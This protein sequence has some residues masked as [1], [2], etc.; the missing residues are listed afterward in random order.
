MSIPGTALM[1]RRLL[2]QLPA[3]QTQHTKFLFLHLISVFASVCN[4]APVPDS[5]L[6]SDSEGA[7]VSVSA[8]EGTTLTISTPVFVSVSNS[9]SV[10]VPGQISDSESAT[11]SASVQEV[12]IVSVTSQKGTTVCNLTPY[13]V[14]SC[15]CISMFV[16]DSG[17]ATNPLSDPGC[18]CSSF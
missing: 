9:A 14:W 6:I 8:T 11:V 1:P 16:S 3:P 12:A 18:H 2:H 15:L 4:S 13:S 5:V 17:G 10:S 7:A